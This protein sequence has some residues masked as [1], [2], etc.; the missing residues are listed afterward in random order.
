MARRGQQ[1]RPVGREAACQALCVPLPV[2]PSALLP[3]LPLFSSPGGEAA[4]PPAPAS[5]P[6]CPSSNT[7]AK[8]LGWVSQHPRDTGP[9][10]AAP[11]ATAP[12]PK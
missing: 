12:R 6:R 10:T 9:G 5:A 4:L 2:L 11:S 1:G 7:H 8:L 3:S